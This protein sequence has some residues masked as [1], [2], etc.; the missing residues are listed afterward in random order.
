MQDGHGPKP[1][2]ELNSVYLSD[3]LVADKEVVGVIGP[4]GENPARNTSSSGP[5]VEDFKFGI[6]FYRGVFG[7]WL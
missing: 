6:G 7:V 4:Q 3:Q 2:R 5:I 1:T